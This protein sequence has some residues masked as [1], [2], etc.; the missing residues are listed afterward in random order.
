MDQQQQ[1]QQQPQQPHHGIPDDHNSLNAQPYGFYSEQDPSYGLGY[2][3]QM[4]PYQ[5]H[6]PRG[7][8]TLV[9]LLKLV[10][11]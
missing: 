11:I 1:Q 10:P 7:C 2:N 9:I 5:V 8:S 6:Q 3:P 4:S